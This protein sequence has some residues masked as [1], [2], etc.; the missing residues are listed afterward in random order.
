M[1][2]LEIIDDLVRIT[3]FDLEYFHNKLDVLKYIFEKDYKSFGRY[4]YVDLINTCIQYKSIDTLNYVIDTLSRS[5]ILFKVILEDTD[6]CEELDEYIFESKDILLLKKLIKLKGK[7]D[8]YKYLTYNTITSN[9]PFISVIKESIITFDFTPDEKMKLLELFAW[10]FNSDILLN[11]LED[12][13]LNISKNNN[14]LL[15]SYVNNKNIQTIRYIINH[16]NFKNNRIINIITECKNE[17]ALEELLT[18]KF[19]SISHNN[20]IILYSDIIKKNKIKNIDIILQDRRFKPNDSILAIALVHRRKQ[21]INKL[22]KYFRQNNIDISTILNIKNGVDPNLK[23]MTEYQLLLAVEYGQDHLFI[24]YINGNN[25]SYDIREKI[26]EKDNIDLFKLCNDLDDYITIRNIIRYNSIK[27]LDWLISYNLINRHYTVDNVFQLILIDRYNKYTS[28]SK[29]LNIL[30][31]KVG[32]SLE[33]LRTY[34]NRLWGWSRDEI[35]TLLSCEYIQDN[36][37]LKYYN[38]MKEHLWEIINDKFIR[39]KKELLEI[40]K[41]LVSKGIKLS[42]NSSKNKKIKV[43][44]EELFMDRVRHAAEGKIKIFVCKYLV[45][46]PRYGYIRRITSGFV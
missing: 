4:Q 40:L 26:I 25:T 1:N 22:L 30:L 9:E 2:Y 27:I 10:G 20:K 13:Q 39:S 19:K 43:V 16:P 41:I 45:Y 38:E 17:V 36:Y 6:V 29:M 3:D 12:P 11:L 34:N 15:R 24:K 18:L 32:N 28:K 37:L 21:I 35:L 44:L 14:Y 46:N 42:D 5:P 33:F 23:N 31:L 7:K 8:I